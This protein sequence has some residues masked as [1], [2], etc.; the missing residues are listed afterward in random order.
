MSRDFL[1][2]VLWVLTVFFLIELAVELLFEI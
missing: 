2:E 1:E